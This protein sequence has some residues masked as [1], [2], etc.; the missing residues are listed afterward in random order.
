MSTP[1]WRGRPGV[2]ERA[3]N[4]VAHSGLPEFVVDDRWLP[5]LVALTRRADGPKRARDLLASKGIV[6]VTEEHLSGTYLDGA[7]MLT[8]DGRP[9]IGV[10][11]RYDRL[12]NF[13]F[14]L[15]HELGHVFLHLMS[16]LR[17]DFF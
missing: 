15:L 17:Y 10:T 3:R 7:A 5:T 6:L 4:K 2:L 8:D 14:V 16:G 11:L 1:Y 12:D 9:V 13:W